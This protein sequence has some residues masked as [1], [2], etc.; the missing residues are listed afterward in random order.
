MWGGA[1]G[2][3]GPGAAAQLDPLRAGPGYGSFFSKTFPTRL[4]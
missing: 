2:F 4:S 3:G 1:L